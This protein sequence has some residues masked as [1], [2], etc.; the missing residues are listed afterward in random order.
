MSNIDYDTFYDWVKDRFGEENIELH[1]DEICVPSIF[2][3]DHKHHLWMNPYGGKKERENGVFRCWYT[4]NRGS[5]VSLV[6]LVDKISYDEAEELICN[7]LSLRALEK[8]VEEFFSNKTEPEVTTPIVPTEGLQLPPHTYLID[9]MSNGFDKKRATEYLADR[10]IPTDNLYFCTDGDY[11]NRIIIPYYT[12]DNKLVWFNARTISRAKGVTRYMKPNDKRFSQED[13]LYF[14]KYPRHKSKIYLTEG[15][16]DAISLTC[17][18]FTGVACGGKSLSEGQI[19]IIRKYIPVLS[20]DTDEGKKMDYG[21]YALM[22]VGKQLLEKGF[23][24]IYF[25]RP[26]KGFKD[27]NALLKDTNPDVIKHYIAKYEKK[28]TSVV[29]E[30]LMANKLR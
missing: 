16:F 9:S 15:E 22:E 4:N 1:G 13:A 6:S 10:K 24:E 18:G 5:L 30:Q 11:K 23:D 2:T 17:C 20:F 27:W 7:S 25:V 3:E 26:P 21:Q 29:I 28:F 8:K 19:E 12:E 14:T